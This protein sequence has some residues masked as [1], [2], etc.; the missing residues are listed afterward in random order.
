M[1]R[2]EQYTPTLVYTEGRGASPYAGLVA[3]KRDEKHRMVVEARRKARIALEK[4]REA[5]RRFGRAWK[6][7][8]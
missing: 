5:E 3:A 4:E 7:L 6:P 1:R 8:G 2:N